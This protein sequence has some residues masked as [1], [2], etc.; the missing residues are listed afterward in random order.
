MISL[1]ILPIDFSYNDL[2]VQIDSYILK[3]I[4]EEEEIDFGFNFI[5]FINNEYY[6]FD[7]EIDP[8][9]HILTL[10][11]L[12]IVKFLIISEEDFDSD[13]I[14]TSEEIQFSNI[15]DLDPKIPNIWAYY[16]SGYK[17]RHSNADYV[18]CVLNI[19]IPDSLGTQSLYLNV[20]KGQVSDIIID[21][22]SLT[23]KATTFPETPTDSI[24]REFLEYLSS[25]FH[26]ILFKVKG[27]QFEIEFDYGLWE[28]NQYKFIPI[29]D[30][31]ELLSSSNFK[32]N[33][34]DLE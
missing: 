28:N 5:E 15:F 2:F 17:E 22:D 8:G 18:G 7:L 25:G 4:Y 26:Q 24:T 34:N 30:F 14:S 9:T 6:Q 31:D 32:R 19:F 10:K 29:L 16:E 23:Y 33:C 20:I 1:L 3:D 13:E 27:E 21:S 11:G 12:G